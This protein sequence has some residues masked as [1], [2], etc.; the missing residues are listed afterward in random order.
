MERESYLL[1]ES[2]P[3]IVNIRNDSGRSIQLEGSRDYSW[4]NFTVSDNDGSSIRRLG[5]VNTD[6]TVILPAG[7]SITRTV[8]LI[9]LFEIRSSGNYRARV[10]LNIDAMQTFSE[11]VKFNVTKGR[12]LWQKTIGLPSVDNDKDEYRN[13]TL[14]AFRTDKDERLYIIVKDNPPQVVYG[15]VPLGPFLAIY[16]PVSEVDRYG[17]LHVLYQNGP[18]SFAYVEIDPRAKQ[19]QRSVYS[20]YMSHAR[21]VNEKGVVTLQGGE[22]VYPRPERILTEAELHPPATPAPP[23]KKN[24][25]WSPES[26]D[27][28]R[29][30]RFDELPI[31][32]ATEKR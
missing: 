19:L 15:V 25:W 27:D 22:Q 24:H 18:R 13:Y 10:T 16:E 28:R 9:P 30:D 26:E 29:S 20:D 23:K 17:H 6:Q 14:Q 1:Y 31:S 7:Q 11:T 12:T 2:I 32:G 8:D 5:R 3:V 4:L 21:L